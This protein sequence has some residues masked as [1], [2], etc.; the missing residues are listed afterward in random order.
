MV[1]AKSGAHQVIRADTP[2]FGGASALP[3]RIR[4]NLT[5]ALSRAVCGRRS[6]PLFGTKESNK[7]AGWKSQVYQLR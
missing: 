5:F 3:A 4:A 7:K 2:A 1:R 6:I